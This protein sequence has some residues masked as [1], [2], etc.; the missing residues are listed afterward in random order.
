M[1]FIS[2]G[3]RALGKCERGAGRQL[4][5][6]FAVIFKFACVLHEKSL[7][8]FVDMR[9][10]KENVGSGIFASQKLDVEESLQIR[11]GS[12]ASRQRQVSLA[13]GFFSSIF[14]KVQRRIHDKGK[15]TCP[16][17]NRATRLAQGVIPCCAVSLVRSG[18]LLDFIQKI[19]WPEFT[20]IHIRH[21]IG[22]NAFHIK[23]EIGSGKFGGEFAL[24]R[25]NIVS[26]FRYGVDLAIFPMRLAWR[27]PKMWNNGAPSVA[28]ITADG[29]KPGHGAFFSAGL[30]GAH[31][32]RGMSCSQKKFH[33]IIDIHHCAGCRVP[34]IGELCH[35]NPPVKVKSIEKKRMINN[36]SK[37]AASSLRPPLWTIRQ[38]ILDT[39]CVYT[40]YLLLAMSVFSCSP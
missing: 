23:Q 18:F 10:A 36:H 19:P 24:V 34:S 16:L 11:N 1:Q 30:I 31:E 38:T 17:W 7:V 6:L 8:C 26:L 9:L 5:I 3:R 13:K 14:L 22:G 21:K 29:N 20:D 25:K 12:M 40:L 28:R 37:K 32:F 35:I 2:Q 27:C 39:L 15:S 4:A 33:H